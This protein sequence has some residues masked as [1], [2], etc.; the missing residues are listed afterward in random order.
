[1]GATLGLH[2]IRVAVKDAA[3]NARMLEIFGD[4]LSARQTTL[5][6]RR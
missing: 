4:I 1:M 6:D 2:A 5:V 3:T